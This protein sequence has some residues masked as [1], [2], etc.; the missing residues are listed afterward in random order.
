MTIAIRCTDRTRGVDVQLMLDS[1]T[2]DPVLGPAELGLLTQLL[3]Y[4]MDAGG[5]NALYD[6]VQAIGDIAENL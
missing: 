3:R 5:V 1:Q 2:F 4:R 6:L